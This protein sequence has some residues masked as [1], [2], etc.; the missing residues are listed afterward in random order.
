LDAQESGEDEMTKHLRT[1]IV[2]NTVQMQLILEKMHENNV[3]YGKVMESYV[4]LLVQKYRLTG[5]SRR[6]FQNSFLKK[7]KN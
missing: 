2:K 5:T 6:I 3:L 4:E 1:Q 7:A